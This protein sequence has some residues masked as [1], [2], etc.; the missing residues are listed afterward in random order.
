[1]AGTTRLELATSCVTGMRSNQTELRS[2]IFLSHLKGL[3]RAPIDIHYYKLLIFFLQYLYII[4]WQIF[5]FTGFINGMFIAPINNNATFTSRSPKLREAEKFCRLMSAE[6]S[7]ASPTKYAEFNRAQNNPKIQAAINSINNRLYNSIRVPFDKSCTANGDK[8][9]IIDLINL[10]KK[11]KLTNCAE[12]AKLCAAICHINGVEVIQPELLLVT[13][14]RR[15]TGM[16]IDHAVL[17]L[18]PKKHISIK[19]MSELKDTIIID[20]WLGF[21]DFAPNV[22]LKFKSEFSKFFKIPEN[23]DIAL[24]TSFPNRIEYNN[25][26]ITELRKKFPKLVISPNKPLISN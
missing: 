15:L 6:F 3:L 10:V 14:D 7:A 11:H 20:P 24:S 12:C 4:Y 23:L 8:Q 13:K 1:M 19:C 26:I 5:I 17:M 21:A 25:N 16:R 18:K 22:E 9:G 2:H